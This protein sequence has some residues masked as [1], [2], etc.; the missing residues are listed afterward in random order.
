MI[1][2]RL[3]GEFLVILALL[4]AIQFRIYSPFSFLHRPGLDAFCK[5]WSHFCRC[6]MY[7]CVS[8]VWWWVSPLDIYLYKFSRRKCR[9]YTVRAAHVLPR[10]VSKF[11]LV[12]YF[13]S[14]VKIKSR[15]VCGRCVSSRH[16]AAQWWPCKHTG[17]PTAA[18]GTF[19][20]VKFYQR[21]QLNITFP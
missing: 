13:M 3:N 9:L 19:D 6:V 10:C 17:Y 16:T 5:A 1:W 18:Q 2:F 12:A 15:N 11:V 7:E 8:C 21:L 14:S 20:F 4:S